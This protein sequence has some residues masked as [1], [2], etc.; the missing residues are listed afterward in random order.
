MTEQENGRP[1]FEPLKAIGVFLAVFG[2]AVIVAP[3]IRPEMPGADKLINVVSGLV[4]LAIGGGAF[5]LGLKRSVKVE[6]P[7]KKE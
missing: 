1:A 4:I 3:L 2:V 7:E 6:T 5:F